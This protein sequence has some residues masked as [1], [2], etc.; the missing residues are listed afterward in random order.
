VRKQL[1]GL[2]AGLA[3]QVPFGVELYSKEMS[4]RTY[5]QL[6]YLATTE[7]ALGHSVVIDACFGTAT[8]RANFSRLAASRNAHFVILFIQCDPDEQLRRLHKRAQLGTSV[9]DGRVELLNEQEKI[10]EAPDSSSEREIIPISTS[11]PSEQ[12]VDAIYKRLFRS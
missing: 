5:H 12:A 1:A 4:Q 7:L 2:Q 10:F 3:V 8:M 11:L 9:S 6:E